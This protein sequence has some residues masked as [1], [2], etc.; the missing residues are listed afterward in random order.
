MHF[1]VDQRFVL[2]IFIS[3]VT[4]YN[5]SES[6]MN[7]NMFSCDFCYFLCFSD[8]QHGVKFKITKVKFLCWCLSNTKPWWC[9]FATFT[10]IISYLFFY[11]KDN[12][13]DPEKCQGGSMIECQKLSVSCIKCNLDTNCI[14]GELLNITCDVKNGIDCQGNLLIILSAIWFS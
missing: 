4:N 3:L 6:G 7:K 1:L 14:Y 12:T 10:T 2:M 13:F 5:F 9:K 11:F 8:Q